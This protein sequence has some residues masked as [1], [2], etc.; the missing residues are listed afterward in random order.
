MRGF[1]F[2]E[3]SGY[4]DKVWPRLSYLLKERERVILVMRIDEGR[5]LS[6]IGGIL[7][8]SGTRVGEL[9]RKG[10]RKLRQGLRVEG[11]REEGRMLYRAFRMRYELKARE[12]RELAKMRQGLK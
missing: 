11:L 8:I 5:T 6:F 4:L 3:H 7:G 10:L 2:A 1:N 9:E 12:K